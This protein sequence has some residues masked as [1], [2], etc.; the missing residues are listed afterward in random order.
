MELKD[1]SELMTTEEY[2]QIT[3]INRFSVSRHCAKG[4]ILA[5][6]IAG[7]WRIYRDVEF[8]ELRRGTSALA[9]LGALIPAGVFAEVTGFTAVAVRRNCAEGRIPARKH[10]NRWFINRDEALKNYGEYLKAIK[11]AA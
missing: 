2:S 1:L 10:V 3:G 7:A 9:N 6:K 8:P 5:E 11:E 4:L